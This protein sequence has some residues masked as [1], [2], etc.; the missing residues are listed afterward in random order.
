MKIITKTEALLAEIKSLKCEGKSIGFVPT[1]GALHQGHITL[2]QRSASENDICVVS[3][4]VNPT[5]FNDATDLERYPR[6]LEADA[7]LLESAGCSILFAPEASEIYSSQELSQPFEFDFGGLDEVME[8]KF[9]PGH[10]NGVVQI[11]SKLF[12]IVQP[13]RAY[14]GEK[15]FQQ[16][17]IIRRMTTLMQFPV[18]IIACPIVREPSGL[19]RS[20]RNELLSADERTLA[21]HIH[22]VLNESLQFATSCPIDDLVSATIAA[23]ERKGTLK[24]EYYSIVDGNTLQPIEKWEETDYAVGCVTVH[25]GA[26]RLIDNIRFK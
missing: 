1:M 16:L 12:T 21:A 26:V 9:R 13:D 18:E 19:A 11:V 6:T 14:F 4:F 22:A 5:Q 10:F 20:S 24:V 8:G 3:V 2:V 15:D 25:C 17:A 23:I 7:K